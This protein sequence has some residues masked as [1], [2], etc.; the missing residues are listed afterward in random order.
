MR[1][2]ESQKLV[3]FFASRNPDRSAMGA[4]RGLMGRRSFV[5]GFLAAS[6]LA[7]IGQG[8]LAQPQS[9]GW[10]EVRHTQGNV[11]LTTSPPKVARV[12]DRLSK[13]GDAL[14]TGPNSSAILRFDQKIGTVNVA[15]NTS[16]RIRRLGRLRSGARVTTLDLDQGQ[17]RL[18]VRK[19]TNPYSRL[20]IQSP[21]GVAAVRG[22]DYGISLGP[23]GRMVVATESG[24]V[25][26]AALGKTVYLE[27]DFGS[28]LR[29][30]ELPSDPQPLDRELWLNL[31]NTE[32]NDRQIYISG[33]I[34][35]L[36]S[37]KVF[38]MD[39][40]VD[41]DGRFEVS[42]PMRTPLSLFDF[43]IEVRNA[44]GENRSYSL[45]TW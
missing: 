23:D 34:H 31:Q 6:L 32:I 1:S 16:L 45:I 11:I 39:L 33:S 13:V 20:E 4:L 43:E 25:T 29:P 7:P 15:E 21:A 5:L 9:I 26:A 24:L 42:L 14:Q 35:P 10:L 41:D 22:T 3:K 2:K 36:N 37:V 38:G 19:F 18:N 8:L 30:D 17:V 44:L 28:R 27:P 40:P 12:G